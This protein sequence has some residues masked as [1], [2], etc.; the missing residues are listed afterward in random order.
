MT[1]KRLILTTTESKEQ[2]QE[3]ARNLVENGLAACVNIVGP[4]E[5]IFRW[6]GQVD[7]SSECLLI[8]K[9][10]AEMFERVRD[11]IRSLHSYELPECIQV[12]IETGS[13]EYLKWIE[14]SV[15]A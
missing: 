14:E 13:A 5:S 12:P 9:T 11:R 7:T 15:K 1:D 10:T 4:V 3:I 8:I 6:K 2:A